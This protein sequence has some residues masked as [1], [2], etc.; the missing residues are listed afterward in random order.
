V[1]AVVPRER[2]RGEKL[3]TVD[4]VEGAVSQHDHVRSACLS[5]RIATP[6][7]FE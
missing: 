3:S 4:A 1:P 5:A 7:A 2:T 6:A